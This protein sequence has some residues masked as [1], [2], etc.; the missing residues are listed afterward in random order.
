M[1]LNIVALFCLLFL[2][3]CEKD[4]IPATENG[5]EEV[6]TVLYSSLLD[7]VQ[8]VGQY[9]LLE[10]TTQPKKYWSCV[11]VLDNASRNLL[12]KTSITEGIQYHLLCQSIAGLTNRA[13][14]EGKS[15]IG[16]WLYDHSNRESYVL[17]KQ[18]LENKGIKEQGLQTGIEL[19]CNNYGEFDG[20]H[21]QLKGLFDG[22]V[23][24]DVENNP[25]SNIV[26]SI[27]S[28]VYNSIIVDVRDKAFFE[29][30]GYKMTYDASNK[31]TADAWKEFKDKCNNKALVVMPVQT[32]ELRDFAIKKQ[33]LCFKCQQDKGQ[34]FERPESRYF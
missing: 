1:R 3:S 33:S 18:A 16:V 24:T 8:D 15:E 13:V 5:E 29:N 10:M 19:T 4:K 28:H 2:L 9:S 17:S 22:Y 25:E 31:T 7:P 21:I 30:A 27:A 14:D 11:Y 34:F 6:A 32:G 20:V 12:G 23:L 26:A